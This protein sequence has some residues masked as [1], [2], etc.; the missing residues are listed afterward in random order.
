MKRCVVCNTRYPYED[1][2]CPS[3][4]F[5]PTL[6]DGFES[7]APDL[8]HK[9]DGFKASYFSELAQLE[10]AN[11]WFMS[12]NRLILWAL[13]QYRPH[14][15][16]LLEIGCGTGYVLSAIAESFPNATLAGSDLF[17]AGL[18]FAATRL[19]AVRFIQ[20]D[21]RKSPF[22]EEFDVIGAFDV[23]E[24]IKEDELVLTQMRDA[25]RP[26]GFIFLTVPQH[27]WLWSAVDEYT[28]HVRRYS[29]ADIHRKIETTGFRIVR[30]TSFVTTLL[31]IMMVSRF[32]QRDAQ[33][34]NFDA[35]AELK[36]SPWL[37]SLFF[38]ILGTELTLI[39]KGFNLPWGGSRFVVAE[40]V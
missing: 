25:L 30:S 11:F 12:R 13:R 4:D 34:K 40:K 8:A 21:A 33:A 39:R 20:M 6:V 27:A 22:A 9:G 18:G 14:F 32:S 17:V 24:H 15:K 37:N 29:S 1:S 35:S 5:C 28:L 31:P 2:K 19:P 10:P 16:S 23:L 3:C 36:I 26:G 7:Y 38:K